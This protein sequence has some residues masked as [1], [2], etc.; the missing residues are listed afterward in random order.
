MHIGVHILVC[1][2]WCVNVGVLMLVCSCWCVHVGVR[3]LAF[4][5]LNILYF[6]DVC[7]AL[8]SVLLIRIL[9]VHSN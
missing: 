9:V 3:A 2:C 4:C 7:M 5:Y 1:S 6:V 8:Q